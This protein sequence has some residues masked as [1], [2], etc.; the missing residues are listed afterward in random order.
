[1]EI[2]G[3]TLSRLKITS[4]PTRRQETNIGNSTSIY[5]IVY[6]L[7]EFDNVHSL[8]FIFLSLE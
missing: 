1:M 4:N 8:I 2:D 7:L 5:D 3:L 6:C